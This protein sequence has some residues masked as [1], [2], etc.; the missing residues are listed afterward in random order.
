MSNNVSMLFVDSPDP[1]ENFKLTATATV[2]TAEWDRGWDGGREQIFYLEYADS[3]HIVADHQT[4]THLIVKLFVNVQP[5]TR[6]TV[7][8]LARNSIGS[9]ETMIETVTTKGIVH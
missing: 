7:S 1:P 2:I 8:L 6:Y 5:V 3:I 9:S 4:D